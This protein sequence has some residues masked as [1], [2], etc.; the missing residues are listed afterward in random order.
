MVDSRSAS[1]RLDSIERARDLGHVELGARHAGRGEK[2]ER[3]DAVLPG[4]GNHADRA[5]LGVADDGHALPVH[6]APIGHEADGRAQIV[7]E[8]RQRRRFGTPA[9]LP[10]P[11]LVVS[12]HEEAGVGEG[13]GE[14]AEDRNACDGLV[15]IGRTRSANEHDRREPRAR[16]RARRPR[17]RAGQREA[18]RRHPDLLV[19]LARHREAACRDRADVLAHGVHGLCR[20]ADAE[21]P[22]GLVAPDV[23]VDRAARREA[24]G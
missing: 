18:V 14:L 3:R 1:G 7:G 2:R 12:Q 4:R 22:A 9:A 6:V 11:S 21:Q 19:A 20:D 5:A 16:R 8:V 17:D 15:A 13:V 10:H 24:G 23:H